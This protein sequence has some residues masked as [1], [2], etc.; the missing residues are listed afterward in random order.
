M[1]EDEY[2]EVR[3]IRVACP[4]CQFMF[5]TIEYGDGELWICCSSCG[6]TFAI[7]LS[8]VGQ[9]LL[10]YLFDLSREETPR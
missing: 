10:N 8:I 4:R 6:L 1:I 2:E 5:F 7:P 9:V 3:G